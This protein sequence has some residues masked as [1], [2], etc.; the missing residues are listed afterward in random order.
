MNFRIVTL[1][2]LPA[3]L[4]LFTACKKDEPLPGEGM[5]VVML[6]YGSTFD[7]HAFLQSCKSGLEQAR[8]DLGIAAAYDI[9][10]TTDQY[11]LRLEKYASEGYQMIIAVGYM[12]DEAIGATAKKYPGTRFVM[13]DA[14]LSQPLDNTLSVL[15][16]VDEVTFPLGFLAAWWA[17]AHDPGDPATGYVSAVDIPQIRQFSVPFQK[18]TERFNQQYGRQVTVHGVYAGSFID[19]AKGAYLS[20]SLFGIGADVMFG[21]GG[22]TGNGALYKARELG[23]Q[24]IGVDVDQYHSMPDVAGALLSSAMKNLDRAIY[25]VVKTHIDGTFN[26]GGTY[27]GNL[28]NQGVQMAPYHDY[29]ALIPDSVKTAIAAIREGIINGSIH[30]GWPEKK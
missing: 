4:L 8:K 2:L 3:L 1:L 29:E 6:A 27:T 22:L 13:V 9:D 15:F 11:I 30:T 26:G 20:D 28:A 23:K 14:A 24:A 16:D 19:Q 5:R 7:D 12:W 18:G 17:D 10:T 21:V 25:A